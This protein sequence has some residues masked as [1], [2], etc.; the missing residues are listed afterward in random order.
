MKNKVYILSQGEH[1]EQE[2]ELIDK[3]RRSPLVKK[4]QVLNCLLFFEKC[5]ICNHR[6]IVKYIVM[7]SVNQTSLQVLLNH[8]IFFL[9][10]ILSLTSKCLVLVPNVSRSPFCKFLHI[11]KIPTISKIN[12]SLLPKGIHK[13]ELLFFS[14]FRLIIMWEYWIEYGMVKWN[15][16]FAGSLNFLMTR[17]IYFS[18][19]K[20]LVIFDEIQTGFSTCFGYKDS[21]LSLFNFAACFNH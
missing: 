1:I 11:F 10:W 4:W 16:R 12:A 7:C 19:L 2:D 5:I 14:N 21:S 8:N 18:F 17:L 6:W 13:T 15:F 9:S 3:R 20:F